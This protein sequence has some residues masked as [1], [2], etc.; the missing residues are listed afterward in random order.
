MFMWP[1]G[2]SVN[3][4]P[5]KVACKLNLN[6]IISFSREKLLL[7]ACFAN[8]YGKLPPPFTSS[9]L[10]NSV[11]TFPFMWFCKLLHLGKANSSVSSLFLTISLISLPLWTPMVIRPL[12]ASSNPISRP[13]SVVVPTGKKQLIVIMLKTPLNDWDPP[14]CVCTIAKHNCVNLLP[15]LSSSLPTIA[16]HAMS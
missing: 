12:D 13:F 1:W 3:C 6:S 4:T 2:I 9:S 10:S 16:C 15:L 7:I 11:K 8:S 14:R 5:K